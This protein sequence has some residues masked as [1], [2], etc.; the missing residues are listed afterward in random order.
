[1]IRF[2][3][4]QDTCALYEI[5]IK[6]LFQKHENDSGN[7]RFIFSVILAELNHISA[8]IQINDKFC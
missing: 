5:L 7:S 1:M 3:Q 2:Q 8:L 6:I 4:L